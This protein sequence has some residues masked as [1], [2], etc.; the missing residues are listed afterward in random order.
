MQ[1]ALLKH[2]VVFGCGYVGGE[3]A[4]QA[5]ERGFRVTA[6]TRNLEKAAT[7]RSAGVQ[8]IVADLATDLWHARLPSEVD[9]VLNAV[10]AGGGGIEGYRHSYVAGMESMV[11][12]A[13]QRPAIHTVVYT[14]STSVYPQDHGVRVDE[15]ASTEAASE[16]PQVLLAAEQVVLKAASTSAEGSGLP[17]PK[18]PIS[19]AFVLRLAG[20]YGPGR[21]HLVDQ[22]RSGSVSGRGEHHMNLAHRADIAAAI[23]SALEAPPSVTGGVFNVVD[24]GAA[25]KQEV[26]AW[27]A[28]QL[29]LPVPEFTGVPV[30]GRRAI[31]PDRIIDNQ[32]LK[33]LL[34]WTPS[35]PTFREG[36]KNMLAL[37]SE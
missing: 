22:V 7:L 28:Q 25:T 21:H 12:W 32:K 1:T 13:S 14:G 27:L 10:S 37:G 24:D 9:Y 34:G 6:L 4:R 35:F 30:A 17:N 3:V 26:V 20:I 18:T 19:R 11:R 31:T 16:L 33:S 2:L 15:T 29:G 5:L 8:V 36:Y 23:W